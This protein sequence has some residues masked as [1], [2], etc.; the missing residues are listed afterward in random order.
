MTRLVRLDSGRLAYLPP[1]VLASLRDG[2]MV[3]FPTD[4]LYGLGV[5]PR[6]EAGIRRLVAAK[7][8]D[9][10]KP[11]PLLLSGPEEVGRWARHVPEGAARLM[12]RFWPG[13]LTIVLRAAPGIHPAITGGGDTVGLRVPDHPIPRTLA[14]GLSGAV[15]GTSANRSGNPGAWES[16][17]EIVAEFT[18]EVDWILWDGKAMSAAGAGG[19]TAAGTGSTVVAMTDDRPVLLREGVL[20]FREIVEY[21]EKG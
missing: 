19:R 15:T 5:D 3:I 21:V 9:S 12:R 2:G 10:R 4:T 11:I 14:R 1:E 13:P 17:E 20:S 16:A 18:G 7:G 6:S 8:R